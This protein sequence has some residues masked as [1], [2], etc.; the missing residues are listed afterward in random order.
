MY[1]SETI[2]K[3]GDAKEISEQILQMF[4]ADGDGFIDFSE[5]VT[6]LSITRKGTSQDK[7]RLAFDMI[8]TDN[9]GETFHFYHSFLSNS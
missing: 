2:F 3:Q 7:M 1:V 4:D 5:F 9:N 8:D 6:V